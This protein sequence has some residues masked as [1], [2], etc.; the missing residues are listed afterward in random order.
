MP[1]V[2][3]VVTDYCCHKC[4]TCKDAGNPIVAVNI[5]FHSAHTFRLLAVYKLIDK[6]LLAFGCDFGSTCGVHDTTITGA[7]ALGDLKETHF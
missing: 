2:I 3:D 4:N 5:L 7:R 1:S 6:V